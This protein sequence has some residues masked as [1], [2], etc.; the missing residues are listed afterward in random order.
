VS[1]GWGDCKDKA[2]V[3]VAMLNELGI[4]ATMVLVRTGHRG[5]FDSK[6]AS[7][8]PFD[9]AIA[10]VPELDLYLDGTAEFSGSRELPEMDQGALALQ[11]N[12]GKAKL[13]TLPENDPREHVK[14]R[15]V[16]MRL[17]PNG[18]A[19]LELAYTTSGASAAAWRQRYAGEATRRVRV[20]ED[21]S[22]EFPGIEIPKGAALSLNDVSNYE[23]PV[24][25]SLHARAPHLWRE[26]G[27]ALSLR[28]TPRE[29]LSSL[30]ASL[31]RRR[32]DVDLGALPAL[33]ERHEIV[34]PPGFEVK[35]APPNTK[36]SG[37]FGEFSVAV[38]QQ[39]G[40]V[41]VEA[42]VA[43]RVSRVS[44][45]R[46]AEFRKFCQAADAAFEPRLVL[47]ARPQ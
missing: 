8:A 33:E 24:S 4:D 11:V 39:P 44:P 26:E 40:R 34:L 19:E 16:S 13:V 6:V 36:Q 10:Y 25:L 29:R 27:G 17:A 23:E 5:R 2:A 35:S 45:D 9:H 43:L 38:A 30:Y 15:Q 21:L 12:A 37:P 18:N 32:L 7:L 14:R 1:R 47:G 41:L 22:H 20:L 31:P 46:Y 28:V 3:I 42:R